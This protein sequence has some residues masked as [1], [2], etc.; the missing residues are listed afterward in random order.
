MANKNRFMV[1]VIS[2]CAGIM[3]LSFITSC[4]KSNGGI[5]PATSKIQFQVVNLSPD[6]LPVYLY[7]GTIRQNS[8]NFFT[9]PSPSGYFS[10]TNTATPIQIRSTRNLATYITIDSVIMHA[11]FKYTLFVTGIRADS[12]VVPIFTVD[13]ASPPPA[14]RGKIRFVNASPRSAPVDVYANDKV[15]FQNRPYKNVSP[16]ILLPPGNYDLKVT[17]A[18]QATVISTLPKFT[19]ADGKVY[20][21]YCRGVA[22]G[23]DSVAFGTGMII[24]R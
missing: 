7:V 16:Y 19:I 5:L 20:T 18:G 12:T 8:N 21:M 3:I 2:C 15:A 6:L 22:N 11:Y 1:F 4:G 14:G 9:Y 17:P 24:N 13:T 23:A 10:L